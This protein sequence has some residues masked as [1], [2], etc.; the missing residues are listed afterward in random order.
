MKT[1]IVSCFVSLFLVALALARQ[2]PPARRDPTASLEPLAT[3]AN[4]L[5]APAPVPAPR[6]EIGGL[7][8][9]QAGAAVAVLRVGDELRR[10]AIG[11]VLRTPEGWSARVE[12]I[13]DQGVRLVEPGGT[14]HHLR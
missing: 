7:V 12:A 8:A 9:V 5:P 6:L 14:V 4:A 1:L 13:E 2:D 10:V 11:S 3:V